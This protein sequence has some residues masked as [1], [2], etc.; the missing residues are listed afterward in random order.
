MDMARIYE[1]HKARGLQAMLNSAG[2]CLD[3]SRPWDL[4][5]TIRVCSDACA[6]RAAPVSA[7]RTW[8]NGGTASNRTSSPRANCARSDLQLVGS[9]PGLWYEWRARL[10]NLQSRCHAWIVGKRYYDLGY[11]LF[12]CMLDRRMTYACGYWQDAVSL[13]EVQERKLAR[14]CWKLGPMVGARVLEIGCGW[15]S[16]AEDAAS[17]YRAQV[18]GITISQNQTVYAA[19]R[20][21]GLPAD[22]RLQDYCDVNGRFDHLVSL[23]M[24]EYVGVKNYC[25][26][27]TTAH[28]LL[29]DDGLFLLHTIGSNTSVHTTGSWIGEYIFLNGMLPSI[30][31]IAPGH[32]S[33]F[34]DGGLAQL[35]RRLRPN[36]NG[37]VRKL[38]T[39]LAR[40]G[41]APLSALFSHL[42]LL[43]VDL[44][45]IVPHAQEPI[46]ANRVEQTS[47][48]ERLL[49]PALKYRLSQ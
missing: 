3:G 7:K 17:R 45:R 37:L 25:T 2:V 24:F 12:A 6:D 41:R 40:V 14:M 33:T 26:Y 23:G 15:G 4:G 47:S 46:V 22:I 8:T 35:R 9:L 5:G 10:L 28:R 39:P 19:A 16:F 20:C 42:A 43:P 44:H 13:E 31:Q 30:A 34:R 18:V 32:R 48:H 11:E 36:A 38:R 21:R 29:R 49:L 27:M 1:N